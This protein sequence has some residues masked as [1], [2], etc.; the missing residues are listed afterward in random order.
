MSDLYGTILHHAASVFVAGS[1]CVLLGVGALLLT[2]LVLRE[3]IF[4]AL[5]RTF[6]G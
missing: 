3:V 2:G 6:G 1:I 5:R 4:D